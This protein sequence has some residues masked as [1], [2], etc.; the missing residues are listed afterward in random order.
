M[1]VRDFDEDKLSTIL[2]AYKYGSRSLKKGLWC[3]IEDKWIEIDFDKNDVFRIEYKECDPRH[4]VIERA[5]SKLGTLTYGLLWKDSACFAQW[6]KRGTCIPNR[7]TLM[8]NITSILVD[9]NYVH[10]VHVQVEAY[11]SRTTH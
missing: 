1:V 4:E 2:L 6:C 7:I 8:V 3:V 9:P 5:R 10:N 11:N